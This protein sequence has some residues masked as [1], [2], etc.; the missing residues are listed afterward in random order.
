MAILC[1]IIPHNFLAD[2]DRRGHSIH[3]AYDDTDQTDNGVD[4]A[5]D[6]AHEE[7]KN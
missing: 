4:L 7:E 2:L 3:N 5:H 1:L 6:I